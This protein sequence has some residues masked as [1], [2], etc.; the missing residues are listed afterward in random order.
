MVVL[1]GWLVVF[2]ASFLFSWLVV[3]FAL[4]GSLVFRVVM[5]NWLVVLV[6]LPDWLVLLV[7]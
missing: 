7:G 6:V 2:I 1:L 5:V 3:L 4:V